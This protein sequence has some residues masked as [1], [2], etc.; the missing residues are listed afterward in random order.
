MIQE[1]FLHYVSF[2]TQSDES[3]QSVPSTHKQLELSNVLAKECKAIGFDS[4]VQDCSGIVYATLYGDTQKDTIGLCAHMDTATEISGANVTPRIIEAYDGGPIVLN[5]DYTMRPDAF[6]SLQGCVGQTLVV[7][8]GTTLLGGDDKAGIAIIMQTMEEIIKEKAHHGDIVVAFTVDEEIGRGTDAF[9][10][11]AFDVD[12]AYTIDGDRIDAIDYENFN[13]ACATI[14]IHGRSI[15]PGD[16][17]DK[18]INAS[19]LAC[20]FVSRFP[21]DQTPEHTEG[22]EGFY[23]LSNMESSCEEA[24]LTY[25]IR[26]H[27]ASKFE[28]RKAFVNQLIEEMNHMYPN[29][30]EVEMRDQYYNMHQFFHGDYRSVE[31]A[32]H[33]MKKLGIQPVSTPVRGGTDGAMLSQKGVI[34]PNLGTGSY[35]HHGRFEFASITQMEKMVKILKNILTDL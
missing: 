1:R 30:F 5:E 11:S 32:K 9:D 3:S 24:T 16:A 10:M 35:N 2:D 25:L 33:A 31:R 4:V 13:A 6:P 15:H 7:T 18:M 22:R 34:C 20:D 19:L 29:A 8:D 28:E 23:Y 27:D 21:S 17:K 12:Y 26:D 14:H